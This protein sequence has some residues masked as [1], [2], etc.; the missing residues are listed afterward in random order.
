MAMVEKPKKVAGCGSLGWGL[1]LLR[2][3]AFCTGYLKKYKI[4][5]FIKI[6]FISN[7]LATLLV[8]E[9][10]WSI[11]PA[12]QSR[13]TLRYMNICV[14]VCACVCVCVCKWVC[15]VFFEV[16]IWSPIVI[17]GRFLFE[18]CSFFK[19]GFH[20]RSIAL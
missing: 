9:H 16:L 12:D 7:D 11:R 5:N 2:P 18:V 3:L 20:V 6:Y 13:P 10:G 1:T 8:G 15:Y 17:P 14:C 19:I 4:H